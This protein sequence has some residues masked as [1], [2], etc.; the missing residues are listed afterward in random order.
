MS[1]SRKT[2]PT[3]TP[4][5]AEAIYRSA[6]RIVGDDARAKD[7]VSEVFLSVV[8]RPEA[9]VTHAEPERYLRWLAVQKALEELRRT[10]ARFD[11]EAK[12]A[13]LAAAESP[14]IER[15]VMDRVEGREEREAL[16][17]SLARLPEELRVAI[18][19]RFQEG[20]SLRE[21]GAA[22][23]ISDVA[24]HE[25]V[26][27]GIERLRT[28]LKGMGFAAL[29]LSVEQE[30]EAAP[31]PE[32]PHDLLATVAR[33]KAASL[34]ATHGAGLVVGAAS[35]A[36]LALVAAAWFLGSGGS[37]PDSQPPITNT[38]SAQVSVGPPHTN[39]GAPVVRAPVSTARAG[40]ASQV[41]SPNSTGETPT[42]PFAS[43]GRATIEGRVTLNAADSDLRSEL[44]VCALSRRHESKGERV[45]WKTQVAADGRYSLEV[46]VED[47]GAYIQ[48]WLEYSGC[49]L[50]WGNEPRVMPRT[51]LEGQDIAFT[52]AIG[53]SRGDFALDVVIK[54]G[55][56][57]PVASR[58]FVLMRS[59]A[60]VGDEPFLAVESMART[61][62][63]GRARFKGA[64]LGNKRLI[65]EDP[66]WYVSTHFVDLRI[67]RTGAS[68]RDVVLSGFDTA[69]PPRK[70]EDLEPRA[71]KPL[72]RVTGSVFD[73]VDG[74]PV[75]DQ[76]HDATLHAVPDGMSADLVL[77]DWLPNVLFGTTGAQ[78]SVPADAPVTDRF[79]EAVPK[80][81]R[82]YLVSW[83]PGRAPATVGPIEIATGSSATEVRIEYSRRAT[84]KGRIVDA[85]GKPIANAHLALT[86]VG[87]L[88]DARIT[89]VDAAV[90]RSDGAS[91]LYMTQ[92]HTA[93]D[94]TYSIDYLPGGLP[95]RIVALHPRYEFTLGPV[96]TLEA[97][98]K[99]DGLDLTMTRPRGN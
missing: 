37:R 23:A 11:R 2:P 17:Q 75:M 83:R 9:F 94:G 34:T 8:K 74:K 39:S 77:A 13:A 71:E 28:L 46:P 50:A 10:R 31:P 26:A 7:V 27:R 15:D 65:L 32:V 43:L 42:D 81:G 4:R 35:I 44:E 40:G 5:H 24:V 25:R 90:V 93:A 52:K 61:D 69:A 54:D 47:D 73:A 29:A 18:V 49:V 14:S 64:R 87:P 41:P 79:E 84:L 38:A 51:K 68:D 20:L 16:A 95:L 76:Y 63:N 72:L 88:S 36:S 96:V 3:F 99:R 66:G 57:V 85:S 58:D 62:A 92:A 22:L 33:S 86:G 78:V 60:Y 98:E 45:H 70:W 12:A 80:P 59:I 89:S 82:Y 56:S 6:R 97:G 21:A 19:L 1:P 55:N 48:L 30:L 67:D 53:E 91:N